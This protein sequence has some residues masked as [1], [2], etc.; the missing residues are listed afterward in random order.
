MLC[1]FVEYVYPSLLSFSCAHPPPLPLPELN[2]E[3]LNGAA[4]PSMAWVQEGPRIILKP[5]TMTDIDTIC[6]TLPNA[7]NS[8]KFVDVLR[9]HTRYAQLSQVKS[10][11][12]YLYSAFNNTNCNKAL[13]N[14]KI[15]K[16]CQ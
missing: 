10:S 14:I 7:N 2:K 3:T 15:G 6:K 4:Q 9:S 8:N 11:H 1:S 12:L 5:A 13:H 16:F